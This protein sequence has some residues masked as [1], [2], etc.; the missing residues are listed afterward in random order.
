MTIVD[1]I[2]KLFQ[3]AGDAAHQGGALSHKEHALQAAALAEAED[4]PDA[5]VLAALLHDIGHL[6]D[7]VH[8]NET[9]ANANV[10]SQHER[11]GARW[12]ARFFG[13]D[14]TEPVRLHVEAKRYLCALD[15][16]YLSR[17][18]PASVRRLHL[19][20]GPLSR[21]EIKD[22]QAEP[23]HRAGLWLCRIDDNANEPGRIVPDLA[24]YYERL[25]NVCLSY[26]LERNLQHPSRHAVNNVPSRP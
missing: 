2:C 7:G 1:D 15:P 13:P 8:G 6:I 25:E 4:A 17:L 24:H 22:F 26:Y 11:K 9:K 14:V 10:D 21:R 5:L 20:G 16:N 23:Y 3:D 12:L 19:Q 18:P